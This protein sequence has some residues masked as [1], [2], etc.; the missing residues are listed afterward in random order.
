M[1]KISFFSVTFILLLSFSI[2]TCCKNGTENNSKNKKNYNSLNNEKSNLYPA[3]T[4]NEISPEEKDAYDFLLQ[5]KKGKGFSYFTDNGTGRKD[6]LRLKIPVANKNYKFINAYNVFNNN[7]IP[8]K[9]IV[10]HITDSTERISCGDTITHILD[11]KLSARDIHGANLDVE[12]NDKLSIFV[13]NDTF[14]SFNQNRSNYISE[15]KKYLPINITNCNQITFPFN[16]DIFEPKESGG[17]VIV[18]GP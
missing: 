2:I 13:I 15:I 3:Q 11:V 10:V 7:N 18:N 8:H 4:T 14:S 12:K 5:I 17:G 16:K 9:T 6:S 1:K